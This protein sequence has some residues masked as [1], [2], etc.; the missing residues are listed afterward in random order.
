MS[1]PLQLLWS[2]LLAPEYLWNK[3]KVSTVIW[4]VLRP[5]R[6]KPA[7]DP[8]EGVPEVGR[9]RSTPRRGKYNSV[10]DGPEIDVNKFF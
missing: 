10:V 3:F 9:C 8:E 2:S 6:V 7:R 5:A 1:S 4:M